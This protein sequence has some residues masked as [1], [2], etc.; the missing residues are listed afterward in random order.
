MQCD[1]NEEDPLRELPPS[2]NSEEASARSFRRK[3]EV[4]FLVSLALELGAL[5]VGCP[6]LTVIAGVPL[7]GVTCLMF[8]ILVCS[9]MPNGRGNDNGKDED[10]FEDGDR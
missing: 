2:D 1:G 3:I 8:V 6:I 4:F 7:M 5:F 10:T 9:L